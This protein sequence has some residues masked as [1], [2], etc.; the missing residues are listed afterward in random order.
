VEKTAQYPNS[1]DKIL[2]ALPHVGR[3]YRAS[4][5]DGEIQHI[6][7][8]PINRRRFDLPELHRTSRGESIK[9]LFNRRD[10]IHIRLRDLGDEIEKLRQ[11]IIGLTS[12]V[13]DAHKGREVESDDDIGFG[14]FDD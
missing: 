8:I 13:E 5:V 1:V 3:Q 11:K 2:I 6:V 9:A 7:M 10:I 14:L 12:A 4:I